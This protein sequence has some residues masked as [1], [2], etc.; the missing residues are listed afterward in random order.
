MFRK[1]IKQTETSVDVSEFHSL[2]FIFELVKERIAIQ[3]DQVDKLDTKAYSIMTSAT[4]LVSAA[5]VLQ[6]VL[7]SLQASHHISIGDQ[8]LQ[9]I[10]LILLL[11]A[12]LATMIA[13]IVA[14][15]LRKYRRSPDPVVL[16]QNYLKEQESYTK[17]KV[18]RS[19]LDDFQE[20]EKEIDKKINWNKRSI[21][22]LW[23]ETIL[24]V[25][26]LIF[27]VVH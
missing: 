5:L 11:L 20:N 6:A 23:S 22:S 24:F 9:I 14:Y 27:N 3:M 18:L 1:R 10:P 8:I 25:A 4:A 15:K 21:I 12:Y 17:A 13:S 7:P 16:Y 26:F 2:E 19:L